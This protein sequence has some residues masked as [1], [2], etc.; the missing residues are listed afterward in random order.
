MD[1]LEH[2]GKKLFAE[3]GLPVLPSL[4]A[5]TPA[6]ARRAAAQLG[7]HVCVKAQAK[8]GGRG[9]AGGIRV[10]GSAAEVEA[11]A[12]DIL[13]MTIRGHA[14]ESLL[15]ERAVDVARELYLAITVSREVRSPL[16]IFSRRGGVDIE[17]LAK[18]DPGALLRRPIDPLL[19]LLEYQVRDVVDAAAFGPDDPGGTGAGK[20]LAAVCRS[21]WALYRQRDCSLVEVNPLVLTAGG[22]IVCLDSK[23]TIDDNAFFRQPDIVPDPPEDEREAMARAAGLAFVPLDGDIGVIGN[24]AGLVMSTIDQIAAAGGKAADFCDIGG[25]ARSEVAQAALEAM[26][27]GPP[28]AAVL[29]N[30][31]GGITRCEDVARGLVEAIKAAGVDAPVVVRL[32]GN[33]AEEGHAVIEAAALPNVTLALDPDE[34]VRLV[35]DIARERAAAPGGDA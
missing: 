9:K 5:T 35:V 26:F 14:V 6:E 1:L 18:S 8:T 22:E 29:V 31:F 7:P 25:G 21:L 33:A 13:A 23:V 4:V 30:I 24:G 17:E 2:E 32:D 34:A 10:C 12:A 27:A 3:V 11:A 28:V 20:A 19:G 16:L 15:V